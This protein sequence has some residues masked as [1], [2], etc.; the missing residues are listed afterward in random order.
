MVQLLKVILFLS[1]FMVSSCAYA[2]DYTADANCQLAAYLDESSGDAGDECGA[3]T[4]TV[5]SAT[6]GASG[7]FGTAYSFDGTDDVVDWGDLTFLDGTNNAS[8]CWYQNQPNISG[9]DSVV[10][11]DGSWTP[12][13]TFSNGTGWSASLWTTGFNGH[14]ISGVIDETSTWT[15]YC[16]TYN[17]T[18][19]QAFKDGVQ[20]GGDDSDTGNFANSSGSFY[21][22]ST[23]SAEWWQGSLD[24]LIIFDDVLTGVEINDLRDNGITPAV[25]STFK[26]RVIIY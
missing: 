10:R 25:S 4:G 22:A 21:L 5:T 17:G 15:H 19:R 7:K 1:S 24:E 20:Q 18:I 26:P 13:Q 23:G 9:S 11:K 14:T 16:Y 3:A 2:T 6:Q 8:W 12:M